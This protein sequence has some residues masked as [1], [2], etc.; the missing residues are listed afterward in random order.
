MSILGENRLGVSSPLPSS[1]TISEPPKPLSRDLEDL[2]SL[3]RSLADELERAED[4]K[5]MQKSDISTGTGSPDLLSTPNTAYNSPISD[6]A[7][8]LVTP[9]TQSRRDEDHFKS[10]SREGRGSAEKARHARTREKERSG[11]SASTGSDGK[12][13]RSEKRRRE[14]ADDKSSLKGPIDEKAQSTRTRSRREGLDGSSDKKRES[15]KRTEIQTFI[16]I[17][18][19]CKLVKLLYSTDKLIRR[20]GSSS[21]HD[22]LYRPRI[23]HDP[24][25]P[26]SAVQLSPPLSSPTYRLLYIPRTP[27][28]HLL[29]LNIPVLSP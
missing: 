2:E 24:N 18:L 27:R 4:Q 7:E 21:D 9:P 28:H 26:H 10:A 20:S 22:T 17:A 3:I 5:A 12:R 13:T 6:M 23:F 25:N 11:V 14:K 8:V 1:H 16:R 19:L 15:V 29:A